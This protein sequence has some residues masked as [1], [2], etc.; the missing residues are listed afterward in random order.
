MLPGFDPVDAFNLL[1]GRLD[2]IAVALEKI[3][4]QLE[5]NRE[6]PSQPD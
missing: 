2:R 3:A 1:L 5:V 4:K 6:R